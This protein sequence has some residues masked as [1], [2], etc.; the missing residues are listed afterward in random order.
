MLFRYSVRHVN[1]GAVNVYLLKVFL[2]VGCWVLRPAAGLK[3]L[4]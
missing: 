2:K 4:Y 1:H 3:L